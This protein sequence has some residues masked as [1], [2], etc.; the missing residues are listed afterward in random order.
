MCQIALALENAQ[1]KMIYN[2]DLNLQN[3]FYNHDES[4]MLKVGYFARISD[5]NSIREAS[6]KVKQKTN[7]I[8]ALINAAGMA[9]MNIAIASPPEIT[10]K[11]IETNL[12][13]TI[14]TNQIFA[15]MII[16]NKGG[17]I[18]NFSTL[19]VKLGIQ[20]ESIYIASKAGV[21]GY[22]RSLAR[23]LSDFNVTVNCIAPGPI[24]TDL[25][26]GVD[27]DKVDNIIKSQVFRKVL[28]IEDVVDQV[29]LL[30]SK[31]AKYISGQVIS[32][33]GF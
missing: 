8:E 12:L 21:E 22:S 5:F 27:E 19:A 4:M 32:V 13:G 6:F 28:E 23:E 20:G 3:I 10:K 24:R 31:E 14:F 16:R 26:R 33:G 9:S 2:Y 7:K 30:L 29:N 17:S 15:P 11:I 25:L 1:D 18:I